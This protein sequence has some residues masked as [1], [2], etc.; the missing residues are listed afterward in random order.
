MSSITVLEVTKGLHKVGRE[1]ALERFIQGLEHLEIIS[2]GREEALVG[3]CIYGDLE[4]LGQPIGR[5]DPMIAGIA[6]SHGLVL[7]TGNEDHYERIQ[8]AGYQLASD[9]WRRAADPPST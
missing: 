4:R 9:N 5:A 8:A 6:I 7:A 1:E 3:G 2:L